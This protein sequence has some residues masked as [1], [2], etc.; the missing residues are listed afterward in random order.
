MSN[1]TG[2]GYELRGRVKCVGP[3]ETVG[4]KGFAK[5]LVVLEIGD[6]YPQQV[7]IWFVQRNT[8]LLDAAFEGYDATVSFHQT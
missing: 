1:T 5:R 3:T 8:A 6:K 2:K 4:A 7:P